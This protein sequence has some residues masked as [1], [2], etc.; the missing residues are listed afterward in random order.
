M[1]HL[2]IYSHINKNSFTKAIVDKIEEIVLSNNEEVKIIDLFSDNFNPVLTRADLDSQYKEK[3]KPKEIKRYQDMISWA[4]KLS[5]VYPL[6]W[7][8]MPAQL[9]GFFDRA[10][11]NGFAFSFD[12]NGLNKLLDGKTA[13]VFVNIGSS[14]ESYISNGMHEALSKIHSV[15]LFSFCGIDAKTNFFGSVTSCSDEQRKKYLTSIEELY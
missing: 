15:G 8:Q 10:F 6:W 14:D 12:K 2:I 5:I 7:G 11:T 1:K 4:D 3:K 9:K 13:Q